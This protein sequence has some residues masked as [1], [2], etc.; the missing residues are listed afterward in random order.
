M[1]RLRIINKITNGYPNRLKESYFIKN[2]KS[3]YDEIILFT[4][5]IK[6]IKF[7]FKVWHWVNNEPNYMTCYCGN[8]VSPKMNWCDGYKQYCSNKC[9]A[10]NIETKNKLKNTLLDKYGVEHYSKTKE[11]INKVKNT[12]I[13][14]W[15]VD[16]YAKTDEFIKKS[17]KTYL[18]RYGVDNYTK[19]QDYIIKSK[20]TNLNRLGVE[21]PTQSNVIKEK[22][23][24][25][26]EI[27]YKEK[28]IFGSHQYRIENF[29][30]SK[31][32]NYLGY[33]NGMNTF[34]CDCGGEHTF[35]ITT[36]LYYGRIATHNKLCT[37][38]Y[39]I[40]ET[41]S[42]EERLL[43][44]YISGIYKD[45]VIKNHRDKY[46]IDIYIPN[47]NIGFEFNGIYWHSDRY[48]DIN[49][50]QVKTNYF[51]DRGIR[52]VHIWEDDWLYK[53]DIIKSQINNWLGL[54]PNKIW[55]RKCHIK[56]LDNVIEF[57]NDNHIQGSD[58]SIIK[59]G[60]FHD[61]ILV[62]VMTFNKAEGRKKMNDNEWNL[63]RFCNKLNHTIVGGASK[64]L[65]YFIDNYKPSKIISYADRDWSMGDIYFKM[66][67]SLVSETKPDYKYVISGKRVHKSRFRKSNLN[68]NLTESQF[69]TNVPKVWDCGKI[70]FMR[71]L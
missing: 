26:N 15:G 71:I 44:D 1:D 48:K 20:Q 63:S 21:F 56:E 45:K 58:K 18:D 46:E 43:Y 51:K 8:R 61:D 31:N 32:I 50:H 36:D 9:S 7:P 34:G 37:I 4:Q 5:D 28:H 52:I 53:T 67:F 23:R 30:I 35:E 3:V 54:T 55:A 22:I 40:S 59:L 19:T 13:Q 60:L 24:K 42:I 14:R 2:H 17:K 66:G 65:H 29:D 16:N 41:Q 10:N 27:K 12:N 57:L 11:Y 69:M 39:P 25:T 33:S 38:C 62:S 70:K 68:T 64:L 49:Y 47:R 6:D